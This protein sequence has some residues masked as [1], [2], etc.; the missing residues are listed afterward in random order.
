MNDSTG[1]S[2]RF[3]RTAD[4][5]AYPMTGPGA[6]R[7][8]L[9]SILFTVALLSLISL[10][11]EAAAGWLALTVIVLVLIIVGSF[12]WMFPGS[13]FFTVA[14]ANFIG[15]YACIFVFFVESQFQNVDSLTLS[16]G[17]A[18]PL[19]AFLGGTLHH[20]ADIRAVLDSET[21]LGGGKFGRVLVWLLP[22][23][24]VGVA[25]LLLPAEIGNDTLPWLFLSAMLMISVIV[26]RASHDVAVLLL[27]TGLLFE[28]FWDQ[29]AELAE[30]AFA[31]LTFYS[32]LI[33]VFASVYTIVEKFSAA[34]HF[35]I[36]G[37]LR[38]ITFSESLYF[39]LI[40]LSTVGYGDISPVTGLIRMMVAAEVVAGV[41]LL[42]FGFNAIFSFTGNSRRS[43]GKPPSTPD[44]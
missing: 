26:F 12:H 23:S 31:F 13:R 33:I 4:R 20:R 29:I 22:V 37:E 24:I 36:R 42:L 21:T 35:I 16:V 28:E 27:D 44:Q 3:R 15:V 30:P 32:L 8:M 11:I 18:L 41:L 1:R 2:R 10:S 39:S 19:L 43:R 6:G 7:H 38:D 34:H 5:D 40:T 9:R 17:F 25:A 14:L